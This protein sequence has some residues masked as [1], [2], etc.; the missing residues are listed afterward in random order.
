MEFQVH[1]SGI[2]L[3]QEFI[4]PDDL[5]EN[6]IES[7][8]FSEGDVFLVKGTPYRIEK[9]FG[10][11]II[12]EIKPLG[13]DEWCLLGNSH[14]K[15]QWHGTFANYEDG[16]WE[17]AKPVLVPYKGRTYFANQ[18]LSE[19]FDC[20]DGEIKELSPFRSDNCE[21]NFNWGSWADKG[22]Y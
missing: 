11:L 21:P 3:F 22:Y 20:A 12:S 9:E 10:E 1:E 2:K 7:N 4:H 14:P 5:D 17:H 8:A 16:N 6:F 18:Y 15:V 13:L 19:I